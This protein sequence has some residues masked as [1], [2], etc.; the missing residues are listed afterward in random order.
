[1]SAKTTKEE[2]KQSRLSVLDKDRPLSRLLEKEW[3][4]FPKLT[5][6]LSTT[7]ESLE[8]IEVQVHHIV[9]LLNGVDMP[10]EDEEHLVSHIE[11]CRPCQRVYVEVYKL[12]RCY[13]KP[14]RAEELNYLRSIVGGVGNHNR[15]VISSWVKKDNHKLSKSFAKL[16]KR[17][18]KVEETIQYDA[19]EC[20]CYSFYHFLMI[21]NGQSTPE[22]SQE[23]FFHMQH[24][25]PCQLTYD[26][27][28]AAYKRE[29]GHRASRRE[30]LS[31]MKCL[32][33][34]VSTINSEPRIKFDQKQRRK[35][36]ARFS[37]VEKRVQNLEQ[38]TLNKLAEKQTPSDKQLGCKR[39]RFYH[40]VQ[41]EN[42]L[43]SEE[44]K[45][46]FINHI[47]T[48]PACARLR[49][50]VKAVLQGESRASNE[51]LLAFLKFDMDPLSL[52][53]EEPQDQ[54]DKKYR[55]KLKKR[56]AK[57]EKRIKEL[58]ELIKEE[59]GATIQGVVSALVKQ[60]IIRKEINPEDNQELAKEGATP[61]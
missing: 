60:G 23:M 20:D 11:K 43:L 26:E 42:N 27:V 34:Q 7:D 25:P 5:F 6:P 48:C 38:V 40:F 58:E 47:N 49:D 8:C 57:A 12:V 21:V 9:D 50:E 4:I 52:L 30:L 36:K 2:T 35:V 16:S 39:N 32:L 51:E 54:I 61:G 31:H 53:Y 14:T 29:H 22:E 59:M 41:L 46:E 44:E 1:M 33:D 18:E 37:K 15:Q 17:V 13:L 10:L 28:K 55:Q 45:Q 24:C 3:N 19:M 56:L